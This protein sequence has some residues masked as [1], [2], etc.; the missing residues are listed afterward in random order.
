MISTKANTRDRFLVRLGTKKKN[1][2][3]LERLKRTF[4]C[5]HV[6]IDTNLAGFAAQTAR[7]KK[8]LVGAATLTHKFTLFLS[9][10]PRARQ[11]GEP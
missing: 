1:N 9:R 3:K 4:T 10:E 7:P 8:S 6:N 5:M 2:Q 11:A